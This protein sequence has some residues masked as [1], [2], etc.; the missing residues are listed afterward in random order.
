MRLEILPSALNDLRA[1]RQFYENQQASLGEYFQD[2]LFSDIDSL[3][4]YAGI[5]RKIFGYHRLLS[6]RFPYAVYYK[7]EYP[8]TVVVWRVLDMRQEPGKIR[9][10]LK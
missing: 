10:E 8:E 1:G 2:S 4:L 5:H 3:I 7:M 6:R 9:S